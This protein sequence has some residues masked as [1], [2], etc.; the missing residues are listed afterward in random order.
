MSDL[1]LLTSE[2]TPIYHNPNPTQPDEVRLVEK[3]KGKCFQEIYETCEIESLEDGSMVKELSR[4]VMVWDTESKC[5]LVLNDGLW[6]EGKGCVSNATLA[7]GTTDEIRD[8][9]QEW[10]RNKFADTSTEVVG[11]DIT[12][13]IGVNDEVAVTP[14]PKSVEEAKKEVSDVLASYLNGTHV[15]Y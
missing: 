2:E 14:E 8:V 7:P 15:N 4:Y 1:V 13:S 3:Y 10:M 6:I 12:Q 11:T 9:I 5:P